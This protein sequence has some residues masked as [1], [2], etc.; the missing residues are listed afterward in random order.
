MSSYISDVA[1]PWSSSV[2]LVALSADFISSQFVTSLNM[3]T[4]SN[5]FLLDHLTP[6]VWSDEKSVVQEIR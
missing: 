5:L 3:F 2:Q 4:L 6:F 1:S